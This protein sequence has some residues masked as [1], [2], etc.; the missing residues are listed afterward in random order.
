MVD[1]KRLTAAAFET[2]QRMQKVA[3][4]VTDEFGL[5]PTKVGLKG[6]KFGVDDISKVDEDAFIGKVL[7]KQRR[8][9]EPEIIGEMTDMSRGRFDVDSFD[10]AA[11]IAESLESR[12]TKAFG[13]DNVTVKPPRDVYKRFHILVRDPHTGVFHEWQIGT[14]ALTKFI[15]EVPVRMPKGVLLHG[16][17]FHVVMYDVLAKLDEPDI[18]IRHGLPDNIADDIGLST[19]QK[20]YD[21]LMVE[22]GNATKGTPEPINFDARLAELADDLGD[23]LE[24]LERKHPGLATKLDTKLAADNAAKARAAAQ[25]GSDGPTPKA[26]VDAGKGVD[27][28]ADKFWEAD[29]F[30]GGKMDDAE[31]VAIRKELEAE[32]AGM[33]LS[34]EEI[35]ERKMERGL[36]G[37]NNAPEEWLPKYK[38]GATN[39]EAY[40]DV[41]GHARGGNARHAAEAA[42]IKVNEYKTRMASGEVATGK[43]HWSQYGDTP[44][45]AVHSLR[46]LSKTYSLLDG[47][48]GR[49]NPTAR[50]RAK[51]FDT[52]ADWAEKSEGLVPGKR[53]AFPEGPAHQPDMPAANTTPKA[54]TGPDGQQPKVRPEHESSVEYREHKNAV[55]FAGDGPVNP[56]AAQQGA[57]GDCYLLA[58]AAAEAR[59]NPAG[60]RKLIK[61]NGDGTFDVT[62]Y[63]RENWWSDPVAKT[64]TID[65]KLPTR[66]GAP[67]YAKVGRSETGEDEIW[68]ALFEKALAKETGS[69]DLISGSNITKNTNF[70]GVHELLTGNKVKMVNTDS[71]GEDALLRRMSD[72]L[73]NKEPVAVGTYNFN[74][75][76]TARVAAEKLNIY[77]NHAYSIE[78]VD[79]DARTVT[80]QNPWGS[81][82][83]TNV[84]IEDFRKFYK[85]LDIGTS[86]KSS[87]PNVGGEQFEGGGA[88]TSVLMG[89]S[90]VGDKVGIGVGRGADASTALASSQTRDE[91]SKEL[92]STTLEP[93]DI[94]FPGEGVRNQFW[95]HLTAADLVKFKGKLEGNDV[96]F[97]VAPSDHMVV[98]SSLK[99]QY[100]TAFSA[101]PSLIG[102]LLSQGEM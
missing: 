102:H 42:S 49:P 44:E 51:V 2:N 66:G 72:A 95:A 40:E 93:G 18:R 21:A 20:K 80:L 37:L 47:K 6:N 60:V 62:L 57:L 34:P 10:E 22:A 53:T 64:V 13:A 98:I 52:L 12:F 45:A 56:H 71:M 15:E 100:L 92:Q 38:K 70:G 88:G 16:D 24:N 86:A 17:D 55:A 76:A 30:L 43:L 36:T 94:V 19:L 99:G 63:F 69:Y 97:F 84:S 74:E 28:S 90:T 78:S 32:I 101:P 46:R 65:G 23:A 83:P 48:G 14:K 85:R 50:A 11:A 91:A 27:D 68:M 54:A 96:V 77:A 82:H 89:L 26:K 4:S 39:S 1:R 73:D 61:D 33:N 7:E 59:A 58:G 3:D 5:P 31:S 9:K 25:P 81:R 41:W 75:D 87:G 35:V 29:D 79:L 8:W 67:V